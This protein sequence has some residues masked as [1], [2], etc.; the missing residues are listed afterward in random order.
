MPS[1]VCVSVCLC[2]CSSEEEHDEEFTFRLAHVGQMWGDKQ[3]WN[4]NM[5]DK[6]T[7]SR[8]GRER[9]TVLEGLCS[10]SHMYPINF[11][12]EWS[13]FEVQS[14]LF[15]SCYRM[16]E[17]GIS[18]S[19]SIRVFQTKPKNQWGKWLEWRAWWRMVQL[20]HRSLQQLISATVRNRNG[21]LSKCSRA[22]QRSASGDI[23]WHCVPRFGPCL[24]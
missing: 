8:R 2:V 3:T 24:R 17:N 18:I 20:P 16:W 6:C 7:G 5:L 19:I 23:L 10:C 21:S 13:G 15:L 4:W 9:G 22:P 1:W 14:F 11:E 12:W